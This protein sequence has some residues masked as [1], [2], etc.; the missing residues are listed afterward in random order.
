MRARS[1]GVLGAMG[2]VVLACGG[3][4]ESV[5]VPVEPS[6][7]PCGPIAAEQGATRCTVVEG[8]ASIAGMKVKVLSARAAKGDRD[9]D[10]YDTE[11]LSKT[12]DD[13][14][15]V[16][17]SM[18]NERE[19]ESE[20]GFGMYMANARGEKLSNL[21]SHTKAMAAEKTWAN[22]WD[23]RGF[24]AGQTRKAPLIAAVPAADRAGLALVLDLTDDD[25]DTLLFVFPL[26]VE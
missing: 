2:G 23:D 14:V 1:C 9:I 17:L 25:D 19:E 4:G 13:T 7:D 3:G 12:D 26:A 8:A 21:S 16:T 15:I 24:L 20:P 11:K 6:A 22:L 5:V 10:E 18:T